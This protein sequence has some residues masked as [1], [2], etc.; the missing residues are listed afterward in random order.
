MAKLPI[1]L[2]R[3]TEEPLKAQLVRQISEFVKSGKLK[4]GA[5][6]PSTQSLGAQLGISRETVRRAYVQLREAKLIEREEQRGYQVQ[7][8][9]A[10]RIPAVETPLATKAHPVSKATR[11]RAAKRAPAAQRT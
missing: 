6:L 11:S 8:S 2:K 10:R 3:D 9:N 4:S 5:A 1:R 7:G